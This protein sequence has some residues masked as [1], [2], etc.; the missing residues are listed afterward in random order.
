MQLCPQTLENVSRIFRYIL[1]DEHCVSARRN[2]VPK[3]LKRGRWMLR[4]SRNRANTARA[5]VAAAATA[6]TMLAA[7]VKLLHASTEGSLSI[8]APFMCV[9]YVQRYM[10]GF[11]GE[12]RLP[13]HVSQNRHFRTRQVW[14]NVCKSSVR[15]QGHVPP[16]NA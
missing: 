3:N 12:Y 7:V 11:S 15:V 13:D 1:Y 2:D 14:G 10:C 5:T 8:G 4:R 16:A 9:S 6:T